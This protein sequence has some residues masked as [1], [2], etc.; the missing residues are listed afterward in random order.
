MKQVTITTAGG[1]GNADLY[2]NPTGWATTGSYTARSTGSGNG[3][4][5]TVTD[6]P[7]GWVYFSLYAEQGFSGVTVTTQY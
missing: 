3:E 4:T 2:W 7:A 5:L 1:T 6:P